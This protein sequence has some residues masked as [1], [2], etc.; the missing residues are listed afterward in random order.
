MKNKKKL[1]DSEMKLILIL[2]ALILLAGAYF[3]IYKRSTAAAELLEAQN[4]NDRTTVS[5]LED[6]ERRKA[7]VET[8][9]EEYKQLIRDVIEKYPPDVTTE[10]AISIVQNA[11]DFAGIHFAGIGFRM[12]N[13]VLEFTQSSEEVPEI[14]IGYYAELTLNYD[15]NYQGF[16]DILAYVASLED[17]M[18][19]PAVTASYDPVTDMLSGSLTINMYYLENTGKEYVPPVIP[20]IEKGVDSIF[21][22]GEG[23]LMDTPEGEE[24]EEG[25]DEAED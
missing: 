18:T 8:E 17:R 12:K 9:T 16:K 2:L 3:L 6:M 14:P 10:K 11:E 1:G 4:A 13:L 7:Q 23:L 15:V 20:N 5:N 22:A 25:A 24:G 21:G 19:V